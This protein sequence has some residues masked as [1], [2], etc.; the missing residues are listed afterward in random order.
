MTK[1]SLLLTTADPTKLD[2]MR[3]LSND[4]VVETVEITVP[5]KPE[6]LAKPPSKRMTAGAKAILEQ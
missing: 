3:Q 5:G 6:R 1:A 4:M 2:G